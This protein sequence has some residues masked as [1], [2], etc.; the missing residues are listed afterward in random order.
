MADDKLPTGLELINLDETF[1]D[2]PYPVLKK[3]RER[4]PIHHDTT[5]SRFIFTEYDEV[6]RILRESAYFSDPRKSREDSFARFLIQDEDEEPSMLL[7]IQRSI[8][9]DHLGSWS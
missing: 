5:L 6:K 7:A 4:E 3:L 9:G 2:D 1:R 8:T